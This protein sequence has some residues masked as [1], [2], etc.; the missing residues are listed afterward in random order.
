MPLEEQQNTLN[1]ASSLSYV[2][3]WRHLVDRG[4]RMHFDSQIQT[5]LHYYLMFEFQPITKNGG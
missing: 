5:T 3:L 2:L 1:Q 4:Q